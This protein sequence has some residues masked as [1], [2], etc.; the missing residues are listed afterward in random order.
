MVNFKRISG[1]L[2]SKM[3]LILRMLLIIAFLAFAA[4]CAA[5]KQPSLYDTNPELLTKQ[6]TS[7][8]MK[9]VEQGFM[10]NPL[11]Y[12]QQLGNLLLWQMHQKSPEFALEFAQ[13][14]ELNDGV[15]PN[16]AKAMISIYNLIKDLK[17][18][19]DLFEEKEFD[20]DI[21]KIIMEWQGNNK[22]KSEWNGFISGG[23][24]ESKYQCMIIDVKPIG[25][26]Q[27]DGIDYELFKKYGTLRWKSITDSGDTD[28]LLVTVK[29]PTGDKVITLSINDQRVSFTKAD[30]FSKN[31]LSFNKNGGLEGTLIIKNA[32]ETNLT[33]ELYAIR[34]MVLA[35]ENDY[36]Y[37][38]PLQAL[39]WGY[40]Y[41]KFKESDNPLKN[42]QDALE[43]VK[44]IW[45]DMEGKRWER[46]KAVTLRLNL[47]ELID[48]WEKGN[49]EY[50]FYIGSLRSNKSVF[51]SK[52]A[53]CYDTSNFTVFCLEKAG[54]RAG[55]LWVYSPIIP[56]GH[57][58]TYYKDKGKKYIMDNGRMAGPLGILGPYESLKEIGYTIQGFL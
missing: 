17:I 49:L 46:F 4:G 23:L 53:N 7:D 25:F 21:H 58:I 22:K 11:Q 10:A 52:R 9:A 40:M 37:S 43:F 1:V 54:Y 41:G 48:H 33:P 32:S 50:E 39:L 27:N 18:P 15:S 31:K 44:P 19:R 26:E 36:R 42:Y 16:E 29:Y 2:E 57:I 45:G 6:Y 51:K 3:S 35:G 47:P 55:L 30:I 8:Q 28:G 38:A 14:P 56:E 13:T 12:S 5:T 24:S 34:D 20:R